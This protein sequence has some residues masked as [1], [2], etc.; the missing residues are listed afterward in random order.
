MIMSLTNRLRELRLREGMTQKETG[1]R[2]GISRNTVSRI[3]RGEYSPSVGLAVR[4]A[5]GFSVTVEEM[6]C[7]ENN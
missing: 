2:F 5:K 4:M 7:C 6:F 1:E 3:E